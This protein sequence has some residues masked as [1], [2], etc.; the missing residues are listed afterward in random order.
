MNL[1]EMRKAIRQER[2]V[3]LAFEQNVLWT[4]SDGNS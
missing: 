1:D 2:R 3:E 4:W